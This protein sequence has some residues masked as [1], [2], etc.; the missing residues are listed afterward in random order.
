LPMPFP[1]PQN[2]D[3]DYV[4]LVWSYKEGKCPITGEKHK[5]CRNIATKSGRLIRDISI[6]REFNQSHGFS[7]GRQ[8]DEY[9]VDHIVPLCLGGPDCGCNF[10]FLTL[11]EHK[12]KTRKDL[13]ACR[14]FQVKL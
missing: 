4:S 8:P 12:R 9:V 6:L 13:R 2:L 11:V 1:G 3:P 14:T 5:I 10:Q 7:T